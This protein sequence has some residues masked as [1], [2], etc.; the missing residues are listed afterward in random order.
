MSPVRWVRRRLTYANVMSTVA[1]F[2]ALGGG[3]YALSVPKNSVGTRQIKRSAVTSTKIRPSAVTTAKIKRGAVASAQIR[4]HSLTASDLA[5]G[6]IPAPAAAP[7]PLVLGG[8]RAADTD[9]LAAPGTQLKSASLT[10]SAA[11]KAFVL[12]TLSSPFLTCGGSPCDANWGIYVDGQPVS[13][14]GL[15]LHAA[16]SGSDGFA[17]LYTLYGVTPTLQAGSH[18]VT[19][20]MTSSGSPADVGQL[21]SQLGAI[22][23]GA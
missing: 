9:P 19:L 6:V 15:H 5:P 23:A 1:V 11:G 8:A 7:A 21:G 12:G 17:Y 2:V 16:A 20:N 3:A 14:A 10:I 18:T 4:D 22:A 13:A